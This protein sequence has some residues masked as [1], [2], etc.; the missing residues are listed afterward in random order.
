MTNEIVVGCPVRRRE[1]IIDRWFD[2]IEEAT[3]RAGL[4]ASYVVV[5]EIE[6]PTLQ[7]LRRKA[8][9]REL[10][11][12]HWEELET[13]ISEDPYERVWNHQRFHQMVALRN[14]LLQAVREMEPRW[15]LS[16]DSDI[17]IHPDALCDLI[18]ATSRFGAVGGATFMTPIGSGTG[19][20]N[21]G[22]FRGAQGF[23]RYSIEHRGVIPVGVVMALKLLTPP[24]YAIDYRFHTEGEDLGFSLACQEAGIKLGW[25]NLHIS[26]HIMSPDEIDRED[27]RCD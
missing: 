5:S 20:P 21:C 12:I 26:R 4:V 27:D 22:W 11:E 13:P 1:W 3:Q 19:W 17:L 9:Q 2:A 16:I 14:R 18:E 24:A 25:S 23:I 6:D 15:F 8:F 10:K 7:A